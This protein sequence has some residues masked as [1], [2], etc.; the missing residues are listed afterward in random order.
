M[1]ADIR[2][3]ITIIIIIM[4]IITTII[5]TIIMITIIII[6]ADRPSDPGTRRAE[7]QTWKT[8]THRHTDI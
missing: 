1:P 6:H 3:I 4:I 7:R 8:P 5:I 2:A